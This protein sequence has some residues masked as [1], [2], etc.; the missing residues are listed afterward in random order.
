MNIIAELEKEQARQTDL[1]DMSPGDSVKVH[2]RVREGSRERIQVF[3]GIVLQIRRGQGVRDMFTV[4]RVSGGIGVERIFPCDSPKIE[5]VEIVRRGRVRRARLYYLR[6]RL[7][8]KAKVKEARRT[9][10]EEQAAVQAREA[11]RAKRTERRAASRD[12]VATPPGEQA[13]RS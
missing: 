1:P 10:A 5:N 3:E 6:D 12:K 8:K 9:A 11:R 4:R 13:Q 2:Y 7:G